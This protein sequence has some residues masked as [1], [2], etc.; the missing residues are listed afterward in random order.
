V[1]EGIVTQILLVSGLLTATLVFGLL[2]PDIVSR[3][4]LGTDPPNAMMRLVMRHWFLMVGL[5]GVLLGVAAYDGGCRVP[6]MLF[7]IAEKLALGA[8]VLASPLRKRVLTMSAVGADAIMAV[9][10]ITILIRGES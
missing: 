4:L 7:A 8:L 9:L 6:A 5:V 1:N 10:F 3:L 2:A